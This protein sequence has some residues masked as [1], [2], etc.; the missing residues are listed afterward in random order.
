MFNLRV[1]VLA[2]WADSGV[3]VQLLRPAADSV[4]IVADRARRKRYHSWNG[5]LAETAASTSWVPPGT[6]SVRPAV[7][8][9]AGS[10]TSTLVNGNGAWLGKGGSS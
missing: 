4:A 8:G 7:A 5:A 6:A 9:A 3:G 1:W 10:S 2:K